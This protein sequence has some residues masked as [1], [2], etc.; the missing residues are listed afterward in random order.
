MGHGKET[1][2]QKMIGMM[3]LVL[4]A[5]LALNVSAEVLNAFTLVDTS[6][7]KTAENFNNKNQGVYSKLQKAATET[8]KKSKETNDKAL[9]LKT[10]SQELFDHIDELKL[11]IVEKADKPGNKYSQTRNP[12]DIASKSDNNI[13]GEVMIL[14]K[15][16]EKLKTKI[17]EYREFMINF[18]PEKDRERYKNIIDGLKSTLNT[19]DIK[20]SE[21]AMVSWESSNFDHLPLAGAVTMLSKLM[22]DVRN[23]E[24]DILA[25]LAGAADADMFKFNKIEAIVKAKSN[26]VLMGDPY[27]AE[28]FIAASDSTITPTIKLNGGGQLKI[29]DGKGIYKGNTSS[30]GMKS[31]GG[32]IELIHPATK[33][34]K[35]YFYKA[36]YEVG[37]SSLVVSPTK[38]NVF[39]IGVPNP[40][41]ISV[42]GVPKEKITASITNGSIRPSKN[43][44]TVMIKSGKTADIRV[45]ANIEG[46]VRNMGT[47]KF[48]V[49]P[50]P[51]PKPRVMVGTK[52][53]TAV[54]PKNI[55][56][57]GKVVAALD[58][59]DFDLNF[60]VVGFTL[61]ATVKGYVEEHSSTSGRL[62]SKQIGLLKKLP[63]KSKVYFE[64]I[65]A[66]GPDKKRR[67][68]G[69]LAFKLK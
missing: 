13:P 18:I 61:S 67:N 26:Y 45:S 48:R 50:V 59:F 52:A 16:G 7:S 28:V 65:K 58:N 2:R 54:M 37:Q 69:N 36:E 20:G 6:L 8:P 31:W 23:T 9:E 25:F 14:N 22:A 53:A 39:Y 57:N 10:K 17:N 4:T 29:K 35:K 46:T 40:V 32:V 34:V 24:G 5:L 49:K 55:L 41:E 15:E 3:Y 47:K 38:M 1:P 42:S 64:Q 12:M 63:A 60:R 56:A 33:E 21:G 30:V 51:D 43:G 27:E 19:D 62:T 11:L 44:Y 68:I 66:V